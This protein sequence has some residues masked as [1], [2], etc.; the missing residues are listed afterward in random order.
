MQEAPK[1]TTRKLYLG[2]LTDNRRWDMVKIRPDD[3][4][5]VPLLIV[6]EN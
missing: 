2:P 3:V 5:V 1:M 6:T 4:F